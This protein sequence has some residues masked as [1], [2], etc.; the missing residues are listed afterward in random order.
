MPPLL[1][2]DAKSTSKDIQ[3]HNSVHHEKGE[4]VAETKG[5]FVWSSKIVAH[6]L[7]SDL[8]LPSLSMHTLSIHT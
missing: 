5:K 6:V 2:S 1:Q 3:Q 4:K 8:S 7:L